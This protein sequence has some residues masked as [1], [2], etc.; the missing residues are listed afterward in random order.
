MPYLLVQLLLVN[1]WQAC[2]LLCMVMGI[3][4]AHHWTEQYWQVCEFSPTSG[5]GRPGR[6]SLYNWDSSSDKHGEWN[7]RV[8]DI[9][10]STCRCYS[11]GAAKNEFK[12]VKNSGEL[13]AV[14][15]VA[16]DSTTQWASAASGSPAQRSGSGVENPSCPGRCP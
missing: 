9:T 7:S 1:Y 2:C 14:G 3:R 6:P 11:E 4:D 12:L 5:D 15:P 16:S 10:E 8:A 13:H